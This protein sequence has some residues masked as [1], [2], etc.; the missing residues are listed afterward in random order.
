MVNNPDRRENSMGRPVVYD[1]LDYRRF[2]EALFQFS[3]ASK[4]Q[5]S[6]RFFSREA[7]F[8]SPNF[9]K[10]VIGGQRNLT[11]TSIAKVAKGFRLRKQ[12]REFFENLVFMNQAGTHEDKD[13][14]YQRMLRVKGFTDGHRIDKASYDY[15][16]K[17]YY[18]AIREIVTFHDRL[19]AQQ[20]AERLDPPVTVR[21]AERALDV[22]LALDLIRK[23]ER[24]GWRQNDKVITTGPEVRSVTVANYHRAMLNLASEA[25]DRHESS[26]RDITALTLSVNHAQLGAIKD[27]IASCRR[28]LLEMASSDQKSDQVYQVNFQVFPLTRKR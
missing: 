24:G 5:F 1:Y 22:L 14:Y 3:K 12:E 21:E 27:R 20:I 18:P 25:I 17:W 4:K 10:L 28:E 19:T 7:G 15:F 6:Y 13:Y 11:H 16:S 2:L 26:E 8:A 9:L 23:G